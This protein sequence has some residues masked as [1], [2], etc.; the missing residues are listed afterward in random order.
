MTNILPSGIGELFRLG[1]LVAKGLRRHG[2]W[3]L[4]NF[5]TEKE[6]RNSLTAAQKTEA[7]FARALVARAAAA[8]R[9]AE[10]QEKLTAWLARARLVVMLALGSKWSQSWIAAGFTHR[11]TNVPKRLA[12]RIELNRRLAGFFA[13]NGQFEVPFAGVTAAEAKAL[14]R[15]MRQAEEKLKAATTRAAEKKRARD[16]AEKKLRWDVGS[17]RDI[18]RCVIKPHDPCWGAFGFQVPRPGDARAEERFAPNVPEP[19]LLEPVFTVVAPP[20]SDD[21]A[22]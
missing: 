9:F 8:E 14:R 17:V 11:G 10:T 7:D 3:L 6:L 4:K 16:K 22:A 19:V 5:M 15:A 13:V 18:L 21:V 20:A 1:A 2:P 12:G